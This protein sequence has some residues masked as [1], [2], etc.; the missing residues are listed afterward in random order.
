MFGKREV[1]TSWLNGD[2][3]LFYDKN[4]NGIADNGTEFFGTA[5]EYKSGFAHLTTMDTNK[6]GSVDRKDTDFHNLFVW[7]D[8]NYD[9]KCTTEEVTPLSETLVTSIPLKVNEFQKVSTVNGNRVKSTVKVSTGQNRV[10]LF[11][12]V[13][14]RTGI[15]PKLQK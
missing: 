2:G 5:A 11:G 4:K 13:D 10:I 3:F 6:D 1:A 8:I 12:D 14:L 7:S 9:G 15:Y